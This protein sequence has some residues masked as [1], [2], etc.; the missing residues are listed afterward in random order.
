MPMASAFFLL[1]GL[2]DVGHGLLDA[3]VVNGVAVVGEDD[4][5][6]VF[7]DV[8]YVAAHG[9]EHDPALRCCLRRVP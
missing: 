9:G 5:D 2:E 1:S 7:A 6:K 4:I 8:V 3:E